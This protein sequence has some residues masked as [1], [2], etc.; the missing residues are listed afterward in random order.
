MEP[1]DRDEAVDP[2]ELAAQRGRY[3]EIIVHTPGG[4]P[5]LNGVAADPELAA[6]EGHV[7]ALVLDV[8][9]LQE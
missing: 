7:V 3:G 2:L 8:D 9:E 1:L 5:D 4:R 6:L